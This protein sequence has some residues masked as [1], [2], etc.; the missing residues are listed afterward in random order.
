VYN[1]AV[2]S[3]YDPTLRL[4]DGDLNTIIDNNNQPVQCDDA[5]NAALCW[6]ESFPLSSSVISRTG[7]RQLGGGPFDSMLSFPLGPADTGSFFN[8]IIN[9]A[10]NTFGDYVM[11]FHMGIG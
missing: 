4:V 7:G 11:V 1:I 3:A 9:S 10:Q 2:T 8:F 6:G 5:G